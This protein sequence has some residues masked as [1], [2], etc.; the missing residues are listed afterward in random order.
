MNTTEVLNGL[1]DAINAYN[2]LPVVENELKLV[3]D[4]RDWYKLQLD[5]ANETIAKLRAQIEAQATDNAADKIKI[6]NLENQLADVNTRNVEL[7][8]S[9][10]ELIMQVRDLTLSNDEASQ[11]IRI[12]SA[13]KDALSAKLADA[14]SFS[15]RLAD[16]L[17]DISALVMTAPAS[18]VSES[19]PFPVSNPM[20]LPVS[21]DAGDAAISPDSPVP[22]M[23]DTTGPNLVEPEKETLQDAGPFYRY[24]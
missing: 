23:V 3:A 24:W 2:R 15:A 11:R 18:E 10:R 22:V 5:D 19:A 13:D 12:L 16:K 8:E 6:S 17:K 4:D 14:K 1:N 7:D 21:P 9:V 20:A